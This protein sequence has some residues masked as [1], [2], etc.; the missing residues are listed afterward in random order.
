MTD[1]LIAVLLVGGGVFCLLGAV[2]IVRLPDLYT[3]MQ[4][5]TKAGTLG[6]GMVALAAGIGF[7]D[8]DAAMRC[9][10]VMVFLFLTAPVGSH[11]I[12]RAA[13]RRGVP[14]W[15]GSVVDHLR[16]RGGN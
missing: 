8:L 7:G 2:G 9:G 1:W 6:A 15:G 5:S 13:H 16:E 14:L 11:L 4:A 12:A 3:R 10:L